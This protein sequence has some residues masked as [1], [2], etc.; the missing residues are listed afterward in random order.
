MSCD[1]TRRSLFPSL[2]L[3]SI[4]NLLPG[5]RIGF[6]VLAVI[7]RLAY[8]H[9]SDGKGLRLWGN[10]KVGSNAPCFGDDENSR[11]KAKYGLGHGHES[12][13]V[14]KAPIAW[15]LQERLE[16]QLFGQFHIEP[17]LVPVLPARGGQGV[18]E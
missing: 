5:K 8:C 2:S 7:L 1:M 16:D 3:F 17:D 12:P 10:R 4:L 14:C 9:I 15:S 18:S 6:R 13:R 11:H